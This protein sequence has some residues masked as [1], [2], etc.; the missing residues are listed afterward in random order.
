MAK[1]E[2]A[3]RG[4]K[5]E[6][7][8][9]KTDNDTKGKSDTQA[10]KIAEA[11]ARLVNGGKR[12][13]LPEAS[14]MSDKPMPKR[15][16]FSRVEAVSPQQDTTAKTEGAARGGKPERKKKNRQAYKQLDFLDLLR[17]TGD[18][19][20][21]SEPK[22]STASSA[23]DTR[24]GENKFPFALPM[25]PLMPTPPKNIFPPD[26]LASS[27][28]FGGV[29]P[30]PLEWLKPPEGLFESLNLPNIPDMGSLFPESGYQ[31][32][33][34]F[35]GKRKM[36]RTAG[37]MAG[38]IKGFFSDGSTTPPPS[39]NGRT[40]SG[41]DEKSTDGNNKS[42]SDNK[43]GKGA[44]KQLDKILRLLNLLTKGRARFFTDVVQAARGSVGVGGVGDLPGAEIL[45][46]FAPAIAA[47]VAAVKVFDLAAKDRQERGSVE[48]RA[49]ALG[50]DAEKA[51]SA[52]VTMRA[53]GG[54]F[55]SIAKP[56]VAW[57]DA[58]TGVQMG[59]AGKFSN[60]MKQVAELSGMGY[61][62]DLRHGSGKFGMASNEEFFTRMTD[63]LSQALQK[64]DIGAQQKIQ[65]IAGF[66]SS[67]ADILTSVKG[68]KGSD[69]LKYAFSRED[70]MAARTKASSRYGRRAISAGWDSLKDTAGAIGSAALDVLTGPVITEVLEPVLNTNEA[71]VNE[72]R[73]VVTAGENLPKKAKGGRETR[74]AIFAEAGPEWFIPEKNDENS[75]ALLISAAQACGFDMFAAGGKSSSGKATPL[76]SK[77]GNFSSI[78]SSLVTVLAPTLALMNSVASVVVQTAKSSSKTSSKTSG[79]K[80]EKAVDESRKPFFSY[81][82]RITRWDLMSKHKL[83]EEEKKERNR[84][85]TE[86]WTRIGT[87][88][89]T[90]ERTEKPRR[91]AS[92]LPDIGLGFKGP[93]NDWRAKRRGLLGGS[94]TTAESLGFKGPNHDWRVN[95]RTFYGNGARMSERLGF[96]GPSPVNRTNTVTM[97]ISKV[98]VSANN[99]KEFAESMLKAR[100]NPLSNVAKSIASS[101][102]TKRIA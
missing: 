68:T 20:T 13:L 102:D 93:N 64:G 22:G 79:G 38:R 101:V 58:M 59:D 66:D 87:K 25:K 7:K 62:V 72:H 77:K 28:H 31:N 34:G 27:A 88:W 42:D 57:A 50:M 91:M 39:E 43:E 52:D 3:A 74:P 95:N 83:T 94:R 81:P 44:N 11:V 40:K 26:F 12:G 80:S 45:G 78:F 53:F 15:N 73:G 85:S 48:Q 86:Y 55:E 6:R 56:M 97:N 8:K 16:D 33:F 21:P 71:R 76:Q 82:E 98:E 89:P 75:R 32:V 54:N 46:K 37:R 96:K 69:V 9:K 35:G 1:T 61:D 60:I 67:I 63:A 24:V 49:A 99:A 19:D 90:S 51:F 47:F 29:P 70:S 36:A 30:I 92:A 4:G 10:A 100:Q 23:H 17:K 5:P 41:D 18:M 2:G 65:S 14:G 84:R